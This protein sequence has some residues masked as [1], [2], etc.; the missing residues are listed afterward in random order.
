M[1]RLSLPRLRISD[2]VYAG[3]VLLVGLIVLLAQNRYAQLDAIEDD[4]VS[5]TRVSRTTNS[6]APPRFT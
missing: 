6:S 5:L 4:F 1:R 2:M 3:V